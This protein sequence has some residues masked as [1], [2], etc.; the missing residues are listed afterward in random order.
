MSAIISLIL[1]NKYVVMLMAGVLAVAGAWWKGRSGGIKRERDKQA[2]ANLK[3]MENR[4]EVEDAV[5]GRTDEENRKR[6]GRWVK[7]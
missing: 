7:K 6:L 2:R 5:A 4:D 1:G 3:R